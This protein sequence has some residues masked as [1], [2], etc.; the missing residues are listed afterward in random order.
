MKE[1]SVRQLSRLAGVSVRTLHHYD[2][3]GLL[4]PGTRSEAGYRFYGPG[5]LLR[6]QQILFFRELDFPLRKIR[7][8]LEDPEYDPVIVLTDHRKLLEE[9]LG[10]LH[11]LLDTLD[12]SVVQYQGGIMLTDEELY[13]GFSKEEIASM[14]EEVREKYDAKLVA[15]SERRARKMSKDD[16]DAAKREG[17]EV[18]RDL[19]ALMDKNPDAAEVQAAV[20]LHHAWIRNFYEPTEE[21]Y[22]GLGRLYVE[23]DRFRA[24]YERFAPGLADFLN[25][26]IEHYCDENFEKKI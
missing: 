4:R 11:R 7:E 8:V 3:I 1:Y 9:K 6:L 17:D 24:F 21:V 26:A 14:R 18:A 5:E 20:T 12:K 25:K 13:E 23:D 2:D 22:R 19:A 15:E 16:L 10:R